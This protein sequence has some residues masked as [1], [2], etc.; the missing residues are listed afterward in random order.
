MEY[1]SDDPWTRSA[2]HLGML[3][4]TSV[5]SPPESVGV[6]PN[7]VP[8][9]VRETD[10]FTSTLVIGTMIGMT[11]PKAKVT[12]T[13]DREILARVEAAV[14][15][16]EVSSVSA[17]IVHAVVGQLDTESDFDATIAEMLVGSGGPP[18][19]E[20]RA[21]AQRLLSNSAA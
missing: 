13:L 11:E 5:K 2:H 12:I 7:R 21:E 17:Y 18:T 4:A 8:F 15:G 14:D 9:G 6:P 20:E 19:D 10:P 3:S 16:G 1:V